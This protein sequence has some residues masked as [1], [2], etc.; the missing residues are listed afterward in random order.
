MQDMATMQ[1]H[2]I[3]SPA[4]ATTISNTQ[5]TFFTVKPIPARCVRPSGA[6]RDFVAQVG[7]G[8]RAGRADAA[9]DRGTL[10]TPPPSPPQPARVRPAPPSYLTAKGS[11]PREPLVRDRV[12][13]PSDVWLTH[14]RL[15]ILAVP[16]TN[17][18][19]STALAERR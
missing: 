5:V 9:I 14:L 19:A 17:R 15:R 11:A 7:V 2:S 1:Q 12:H 16:P 8:C 18:K 10:R 4:P 13:L 6:E 3:T